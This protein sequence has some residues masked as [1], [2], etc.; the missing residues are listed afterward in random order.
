MQGYWHLMQGV[1]PIS[2]K[3]PTHVM[4][5]EEEVLGTKKE[6]F[7]QVVLSS[8][9]RY[10]PMKWSAAGLDIL[11]KGFCHARGSGTK[12][13]TVGKLAP[14]DSMQGVLSSECS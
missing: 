1:P 9:A 11:C 4:D 6:E 12:H 8:G 10:L 7:M 14:G 13:Q 2:C 3:V 5:Q